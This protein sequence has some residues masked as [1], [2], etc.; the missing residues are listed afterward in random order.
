MNIL[1]AIKLSECAKKMKNPLY[2]TVLSA[3]HLIDCDTTN[4][5]CNGGWM[6]NAL[7]KIENYY[8]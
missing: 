2:D 4:S 7:S 1:N 3:Q 6:T 8:Q 5:G